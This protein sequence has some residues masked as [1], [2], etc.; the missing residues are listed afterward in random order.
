MRSSPTKK[1][2]VARRPRS[3]KSGS[4]RPIGARRVKAPPPEIY[5]KL[6]VH[7][8]WRPYSRAHLRNKRGYVYLCWRD[9]EKV[10]NYYL[11]KA[12]RKSPTPAIAAAAPRAR[13][14]RRQ[15]RPAGSAL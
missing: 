2:I 8:V 6:P 10:K 14:R 3:R 7:D 13:R 12:P 11:G 4:F 5:V 1:T 9:G 15:A